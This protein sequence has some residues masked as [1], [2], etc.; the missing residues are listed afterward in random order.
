MRLLS[1]IL[2]SLSAVLCLAAL[3]FWARSYSYYEGIVR[4]G[5]QERANYAVITPD[6]QRSEW[7][8]EGRTTGVLSNQGSLTLASIVNPVQEQWAWFSWSHPIKQ[9]LSTN[10][11]MLMRA[12]IPQAGFSIGTGKATVATRGLPFELESKTVPL[13]LPYWRIT[14]PYILLALLTAILPVRWFMN[15]RLELRRERE[16]RCIHCG[17]DLKGQTTGNCPICAKPVEE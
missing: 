17:H 9:E 14:I 13:E 16:G 1:T 15:Y 11:M 10:T 5:R 8:A 3:F 12:T 7:A 4:Y 6:G 2:A